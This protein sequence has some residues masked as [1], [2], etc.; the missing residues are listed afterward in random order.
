MSNEIILPERMKDWAVVG[1]L[2]SGGSGDVYLAQKADGEQIQESAIKIIRIP[3]D[4]QEYQDLLDENGEEETQ[5]IISGIEKKYFEEIQLMHRLKDAHYVVEIEDSCSVKNDDQIGSTFYIRMEKLTPLLKYEK[6]RALDESAVIKIGMDICRA[7]IDC[8]NA[9]IVH[10]DIKPENIFYDEKQ[11]CFKLG[12]FGISK[13]LK[14]RLVKFTNSGTPGYIAP[15]A[16][17]DGKYDHRA[18]LY[19]LGIVLYKLANNGRH[20]FVNVSAD[21]ADYIQFSKEPIAEKPCNASAGLFQVIRKATAP[22]PED[23]FTCAK[24]MLDALQSLQ[25]S[26]ANADLIP[27]NEQ[28]YLEYSANYLFL[29]GMQEKVSDYLRLAYSLAFDGYSEWLHCLKAMLKRG[30]YVTPILYR[31]RFLRLCL[32]MDLLSSVQLLEEIRSL[33]GDKGFEWSR[34]E[35]NDESVEKKLNNIDDEAFERFVCL[36]PEKELSTTGFIE[37]VFQK[38]DMAGL[39]KMK[40][41]HDYRTIYEQYFTSLFPECKGIGISIWKTYLGKVHVVRNK[42]SHPASLNEEYSFQKIHESLEHFKRIVKCLYCD[43]LKEHYNAFMTAIGRHKDECSFS[44]YALDS[45]LE[46]IPAEKRTEFIDACKSCLNDNVDW[47]TPG[48]VYCAPNSIKV[49]RISQ[50]FSHNQYPLEQETLNAIVRDEYDGPADVPLLGEI[51]P[52]K[53]GLS[54]ALTESQ[55]QELCSTHRIFCDASVLS[56]YRGRQMLQSKLFGVFTEKRPLMITTITRYLLAFSEKNT[57]RKAGYEVFRTLF[58]QKLASVIGAAPNANE[59][60]DFPSLKRILAHFADMRICLITQDVEKAVKEFPRADYPYL[61]IATVVPPILPTQQP[62]FRL[63]SASLPIPKYGSHMQSAAA[64]R[65][66]APQ[67]DGSI[68]QSRAAQPFARR[69][70]PSPSAPMRKSDEK[71]EREPARQQPKAEGT[72]NR[73]APPKKPAEA[74]PAQ[75]MPQNEPFSTPDNKMPQ[76]G[77]ALPFHKGDILMADKTQQV[78]LNDPLKKWDGSSALGGQGIVLGVDQEGMVAKLYSAYTPDQLAKTEKKL[79]AMAPH[80]P[81]EWRHDHICKPE[82]LLY[83]TQGAFVG[84][85]MHRVPEGHMDLA[86]FFSLISNTNQDEIMKDW[87]RLKLV[88]V[89]ISIAV[90]LQLLHENGFLMGDMNPNNILI[91][92]EDATDVYFVDCDSYQ[93]SSYPAGVG[94]DDY[95][96]PHIWKECGSSKKIDYSDIMRTTDDENYIFALLA[97]QILFCGSSPFMNKSGKSLREVVLSKEFPISTDR[98]ETS[99][100]ERLIWQNLPKRIQDLFDDTFIR[101]QPADMSTWIDA[102][103]DYADLIN[104]GIARPNDPC[105]YSNDLRPL[106]FREYNAF[107]RHYQDDICDFC[108]KEWNYPK[109]QD[110]RRRPFCLSCTDIMKRKEKALICDSCGV[111]FEGVF[112]QRWKKN[113]AK[114]Y[115]ILCPVCKPKQRVCEICGKTA[116]KSD[117]EMQQLHEQKFLALC[118]DCHRTPWDSGI[119]VVCSLCGQS[120]IESKQTIVSVIQNNQKY[121]CPQHRAKCFICGQPTFYSADDA[122]AQRKRCS[123]CYTKFQSRNKYDAVYQM[124]ERNQKND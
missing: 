24:G 20:P 82:K 95:I 43:Q 90:L 119:S 96:P 99:S 39:I 78:R 85:L 69:A 124:K 32:D 115:R 50:V 27:S 60:T 111:E 37:R 30:N 117:R 51:N 56:S 67:T 108:K 83:N 77:S 100:N 26:A 3:H 70:A 71:K 76:P 64:K 34:L 58:Q 57:D 86:D 38:V 79:S 15:E 44:F 54:A 49:I 66:P 110:G 4:E 23:R 33:I 62:S 19:S 107:Q 88:Q 116:W 97:F 121:I 68:R 98:R 91:S 92:S 63:A 113:N 101:W 41:L 105:A 31:E 35:S 16:Y 61:I 106:K 28:K 1:S 52:G 81:R 55:L 2:G 53:K 120:V 29:Y 5:S 45:L 22:R 48:Y 65:T 9:K 7:L 112:E 13:T 21:S 6:S 114:N 84:F 94:T 25:S 89:T 103:K 12:D 46:G 102:L 40:N 8:E 122:N 118:Q 87:T 80:W 59:K 10:R 47:S 74:G 17:I 104:R 93:F 18:D 109:P 36:F 123:Q 75:P 11:D 42:D 72:N 14:T 73:E